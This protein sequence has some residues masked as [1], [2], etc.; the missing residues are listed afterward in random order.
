MRT[1]RR[2]EPS[3]W[4]RGSPAPQRR[5]ALFDSTTP[6]CSGRG[7][8]ARG[9]VSPCRDAAVAD[10]LDAL[11]REHVVALSLVISAPSSFSLCFVRV[12]CTGVSFRAVSFTFSGVSV[13][14]SNTARSFVATVGTW[15][16]GFRV[17]QLAWA[18][19]C[20]RYQGSAL[21]WLDIIRA[22]WWI[23][24]PLRLLAEAVITKLAVLQVLEEGGSAR[25]L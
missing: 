3:I 19:S 17:S 1:R 25:A 12:S 10:A 24:S 11:E 13:W 14:I 22:A 4:T 21:K 2:V 5:W 23:C 6:L 18:G 16:I 7:C 20:A 9:G 15:M 8:L